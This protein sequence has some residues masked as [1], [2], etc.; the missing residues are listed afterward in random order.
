M[1][2]FKWILSFIVLRDVVINVKIKEKNQ[3][4]GMNS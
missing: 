2:F 4:Y 1:F 3:K